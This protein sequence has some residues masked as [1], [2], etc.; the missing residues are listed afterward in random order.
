MFAR[1]QYPAQRNIWMSI[2]SDNDFTNSAP[3]IYAEI[4]PVFVRAHALKV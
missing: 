3:R 2:N 4:K 1:I